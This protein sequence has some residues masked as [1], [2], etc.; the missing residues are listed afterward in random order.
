MKKYFKLILLLIVANSYAQTNF[1]KG[2]V[3]LNDGSVL[4]GLIDYRDWKRTPNQI[5]FKNSVTSDLISYKPEQLMSFSV[6]DDK[7][8]SRLVMLDVT[9]QRI[10]KMDFRDEAKLKEKHIFLNVLVVGEIDLYA[11][12]DMR[13]HLFVMKNNDKMRELIY[14][15][16]LAKNNVDIFEYKKYIG[17][18]KLL[19]KDCESVKINDKINFKRQAI[20]KVIREYNNCNQ[21]DSTQEY[22]KKESSNESNLFVFVGASNSTLRIQS[23][24]F[25]MKNFVADE[26]KQNFKFGLA[27]EFVLGKSLKRW[28]I[29]NQISYHSYNLFFSGKPQTAT[30]VYKDYK[31]K[32]NV[33][34]IAT[35]L[36]YKIK[37]QKIKKFTPFVNLGVGYNLKISSKSSYAKFNTVNGNSSEIGVEP[38]SNFYLVGGAGVLY[39]KF[40]MELRYLS[41]ND[42]Y[43]SPN[44]E[45]KL[46]ELGIVIGYSIL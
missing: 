1:V 3:T 42:I 10:Q 41:I 33:F 2:Q 14:R 36:R 40:S 22:F 17:Q 30:V 34:N 46:S 32:E 27:Y 23:D 12:Q 38:N 25:Y 16:K 9:E 13:Q 26:S 8:I 20:A 5:A 31:F 6:Q 21:D 4:T 44:T 19:T 11:Y 43:D 7:Y 35:L 37:N 18:L 24:D 15:K 45:G 29:Y 28:S 39:K